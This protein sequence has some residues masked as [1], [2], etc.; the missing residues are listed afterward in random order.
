MPIVG[1][2]HAVQ[3]LPEWAA[4]QTHFHCSA[5]PTPLCFGGVLSQ[6][7]ANGGCYFSSTLIY[8]VGARH[9][10]QILPEWAAVQI[11]PE[12]AAVQ[13]LSVWTAV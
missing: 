12:W 5:R 7:F 2:R 3:I 6:I 11:L 1:A 8:R 13:I 10:V 4:V 9:A